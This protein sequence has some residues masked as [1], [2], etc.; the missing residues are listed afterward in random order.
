[1]QSRTSGSGALLAEQETLTTELQGLNNQEQ[2][3]KDQLRLQKQYFNVFAEQLAVDIQL[4]PNTSLWSSTLD[5]LH[6]Q[7]S[8]NH[9][10]I[11]KIAQ[12]KRE[13]KQALEL[14]TR[15]LQKLKTTPRTQAIDTTVQ[16][17]C[18]R[19]PAVSLSYTTP[20][21]S[22]MPEYD[23]S[24]SRLNREKRQVVLTMSANISQS[25][26]EDWEDVKL[27][28]PQLDQAWALKPLIL[29][30]FG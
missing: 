22:W 15:K 10:A 14:V 26:G 3:I 17:K 25:T 5:Q 6:Q 30:T 23:V 21:A 7:R 9:A 1:M 12:K 18:T 4:K 28:C 29:L 8:N 2:S 13:T 24:F 11:G 16:V 27:Y 20:Q 19:N